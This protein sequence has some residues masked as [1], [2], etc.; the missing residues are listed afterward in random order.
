MGDFNIDLLK[1]DS[2]LPTSEFLDLNL[3][4]SMLPCIN[5]PTRVTGTTATL[6]DNI[7]TNLPNNPHNIQVIIP[8]DISD[9]F[10]VCYFAIDLCNLTEKENIIRRRDFSKRNMDKFSEKIKLSAGIKS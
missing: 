4:N 10:P 3:A 2:H 8:S 9:H 5:K 6:I 1:T 7:F